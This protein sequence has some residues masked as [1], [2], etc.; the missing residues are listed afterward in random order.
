MHAPINLFSAIR[1]ALTLNDIQRVGNGNANDL[2]AATKKDET[3]HCS[4]QIYQNVISLQINPK[5][6]PILFLKLSHAVS[7]AFFSIDSQ[8]G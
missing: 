2:H 1:D 6:R 3:S 4:A 8:L 7:D 5:F